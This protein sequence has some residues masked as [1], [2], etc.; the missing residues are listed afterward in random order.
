[1]HTVKRMFESIHLVSRV[2]IGFLVFCSLPYA[3]AQL[4]YPSKPIRII[5]PLPPGST[6]DVM[7]RS[8]SYALGP[9]LGQAI[10]VENKIG[11]NGSIAMDACAKASPDGYTLCLPDGNILTINPLAY[12]KL[13][14]EAQDFTPIIHIGDMEQ[15]IVINSS[16]PAK[17]MKEFIDYAKSR[18]GQVTW[19]S[20][21]RGSTMHLYMEWIQAK[22][23]V[24]FNHILYKGPADLSR[25]LTI[26]EVESSNLS[27]ATV[28][29]MVKEGKL[30]MIAVI[31]GKQRSIHAGDAPSFSDQGFDLDF[32]NWLALVGPKAMPPEIVK[33][34]NLA[35][36]G[37]LSDKA[38][39]EKLL[40]SL[41]VT[42][43]GGTSEDLVLQLERKKKLGQELA[44]I[45]NLKAE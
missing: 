41:A 13:S 44:R 45:A 31:T 42:S 5:V 24:S 40:P 22:T 2:F 43:A 34:W 21:G 17:N 38:F 6:L 39:T 8:I 7:A 23:G 36:N 10:V 16:V 32:R 19:G 1:M 29:P 3:H 11:A 12:E 18:P 25:A 30:K 20:G 15:S 28:S 26:G 14:Y 9:N 27:T 4:N 37:L 33:K 35:V